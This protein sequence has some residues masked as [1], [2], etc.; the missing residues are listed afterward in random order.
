[1]AGQSVKSLK[2]YFLTTQGITMYRLHSFGQSGNSFKVAFFLQTLGLP[3]EPVFVDFMNGATRSPEWRDQ[4]NPMGEAPVLDD[5]DRSLTQSGAILT[6]LAQKHAPAYLG[7]TP[8]DQLEVLRWLL[9]DNHKFTGY[10]APYRFM[11][12]FGPTAPDPAVMAWLRGRMDNAFGI[13]DKHLATRSFL[14]GDEPTV[15]DFSMCGYMFYPVEESGYDVA[16]RF[17]H[18]QRWIDRLRQLPGWAD[19]YS[20]LPGERILPKW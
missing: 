7:R 17:P 20:V 10:F 13:V 11:K 15:A 16:G 3:W 4:T 14:V 12:A 19:P 8:E 18:I 6:Y 9:F 5:G 2:D 1:M